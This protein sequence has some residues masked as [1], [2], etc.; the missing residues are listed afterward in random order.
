VQEQSQVG[1]IKAYC[2]G[3]ASFG[4]DAA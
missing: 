1:Q 4:F 2:H 3:F